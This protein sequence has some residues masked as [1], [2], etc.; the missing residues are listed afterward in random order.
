MFFVTKCLVVYGA[1]LGEVERE[2]SVFGSAK[3]LRTSERNDLRSV[4]ARFV[5]KMQPLKALLRGSL[6]EG[7]FLAPFRFFSSFFYFAF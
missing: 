4:S 1:R 5:G 3:A 6:S 2:A 7:L